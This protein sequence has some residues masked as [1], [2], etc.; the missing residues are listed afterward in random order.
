[1]RFPVVFSRFVGGAAGQP[2]LG[3]DT[4]PKSDT[5][6][7]AGAT[8]TNSGANGPG[9]NVFFCNRAAMTGF[10]VQ[11]LAIGCRYVGAAT[12]AVV[13]V[14]VYIYDQASGAWFAMNASVS[15]A[16]TVTTAAGVVPT[17]VGTIVYTDVPCLMDKPPIGANITDGNATSGIWVM[18]VP[19][20]TG[21]TL[22]NGEYRF[23]VGAVMS[24]SP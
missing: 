9:D 2:T 5:I 3:G 14:V 20:N 1:M 17:S 12:P 15:I 21:N 16:P 18:I 13:P 23:I 24:S 11:R 7:A 8:G 4:I 22:N 19:A 6:P 10:P